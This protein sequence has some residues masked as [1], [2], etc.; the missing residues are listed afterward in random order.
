MGLLNHKTLVA[1]YSHLNLAAL[2]IL[3]DAVFAGVR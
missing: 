2:E 3:E 1:R